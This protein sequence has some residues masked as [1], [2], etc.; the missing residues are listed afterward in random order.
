MTDPAA[1]AETG[2][3]PAADRGAAPGTRPPVIRVDRVSKRFRRSLPGD[4]LRTL[5]S[6]LVGGSRTRDLPREATIPAIEEVTFE[7]TRG[8]SFG[9]IGGNG[10][11]KSTLLK[12]VAGMLHPTTGELA[13]DGRV[14]ALIELGAGFHP[15]ISGR[16]NVYI[17]GAV[18]GLSRRQIDRRYREIVEFSGLGEF[19]EEP[20]KN[21]SSGMYVRLGFAV[22][23]HTEPDVLLVDEVLAVG[24]EAFAHR[25][26]RRLE[27]FLASGRTLLLV[28]H[29]LDLVAELCDRVLWLDRGCQRLIGEPRRVVDAYRQAVAEQEGAEHLAANQQRE[30]ETDASAGDEPRRWGSRQAEVTAVRLLGA[31]GSERYHLQTGEPA[32]FEIHARAAQPLAD[33]VFGIAINTPRGFECWGTN[34]DLEGF[35]PEQLSGEAVVRVTCPA[36]RLAPGEYAVDV[37]VHARDG[38]PYDYHRRVL[39]FT[40]TA[41]TGGAGVYFPEHRWEFAGGVRW[42]GPADPPRP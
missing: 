31:D 3:T 7:V 34:T 13:V 12:L 35:V 32:V 10:S 36:L 29:S 9:V 16:E 18:L 2:R 24:D 33:F 17:N 42:G 38:A 30:Q 41:A 14:A 21:Y 25:C 22:A 39:G 20:V 5:K 40:V 8:E 23:I 1:I 37:A 27:E 26:I 15:E 11:G 4:R 28:S 19:M 6:A